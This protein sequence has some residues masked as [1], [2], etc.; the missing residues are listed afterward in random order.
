MSGSLKK[1]IGRFCVLTF[2]L[3]SLG[4]VWLSPAAQQAVA[5]PCCQTCPGG[6][7]PDAE[8]CWDVCST[9][10]D[11]DCLEMCQDA[12]IT[13]MQ[14][15]TSCGGGGG[16][17]TVGGS[18]SIDSHCSPNWRCENGRCYLGGRQCY[19]S[20][21]CGWGQYCWYGQCF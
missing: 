3:V 11:P 19:T 5:S 20:S 6:Y 18:C 14:T 1:L 21:S 15:C 7:P 12:Q 17:S 9:D 8:Y 10:P 13:C 4:Y 2:L 16:G